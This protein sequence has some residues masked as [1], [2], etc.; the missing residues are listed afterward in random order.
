MGVRRGVRLVLTPADTGGMRP[1]SKRP[2]LLLGLLCLAS[3]LLILGIGLGLIPTDPTDIHAPPWVLALCGLVF[4]LGGVAVFA[5]ERP[6]VQSAAGTTI[7]L[8]FRL[9][10]GWVAL[11]GASG[12]MSGGVPFLP[13]GVNI[14]IGRGLFGLGALMCLVLFVFGVR[15]ILRGET[16]A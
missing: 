4:I 12:Q 13:R 3:G 2:P 10:G 16:N 9:V 11:F 15:Q 1:A 5:H 7:V 6:R 8:A 14:A